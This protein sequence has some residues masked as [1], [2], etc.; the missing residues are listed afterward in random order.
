MATTAEQIRRTELTG[1]AAIATV[2]AFVGAMFMG[3]TLVTPL[4]IIY[5]QRFHFSRITLTL[6][7]AAYVVGNL[8]ALLLLGRLS[9]VVG[10]R[11]ISLVA[12]ATAFTSTFLF[13]FAGSTAW[14]FFARILSGLGVG[15]SAGTATAWIAE[16]DKD[17]DKS[18]ATLVA[19][20]S[21]FAGLAI[22]SMLAGL[23]AEYAPWPLHL[24]FVVYLA[25]LAVITA[26][27]LRTPETVQQTDV[28]SSRISLRPRLGVPPSIRAQFIAP[29]VT[30][31]GAMALVGFYAAVIPSILAD[32]LGD[33]NHAT[34][35]AVVFELA[36]IVALTIILTRALRSRT[37]M[38]GGLILLLPSLAL[39]VAAEWFSSITILLVGTAVSGVAAAL[40]YRSSLQVVNQIA[41]ADRRAEVTSSYFVAGFTG[42]AV[43]VIGVGI[44]AT[45]ASSMVASLVFALTI[46]AFAVAALFVGFKYLPENAP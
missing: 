45:L 9:D 3:S 24:P 20:S 1:R 46:A 42:N 28:S 19:T 10:R 6:V 25:L 13:L 4:Y 12:L 2:A 32:R 22:G 36:I 8:A 43:P 5:E 33:K 11:H 7:Y 26:G 38:L 21:N 41:P 40:G 14:L 35:G 29:A 30:V 31:F 23:L 16:L 44:I 39:L 17:K 34:A 18:R 27:I 15:L 37:A